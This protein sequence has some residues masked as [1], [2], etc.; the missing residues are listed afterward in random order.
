MS[1]QPTE[2]TDVFN[3]ARFLELGP[4]FYS[5]VSPSPLRNPAMLLWNSELAAELSLP[6]A[7]AHSE[8]NARLFSG[9]QPEGSENQQAD[10]FASVYSG[11]QFGV[12]AGQLGDGRAITL[13]ELSDRQ[14]TSQ[15]IQLKGAG[16]TPYSR[17]GDGR[18]VLRSSIREYLC[19]EAMHALG[20]PTTRALSLCGATDFVFREQPEN[21][22]V[23]CRVA[24]S[25][26]RFG[27]FE[28][29]YYQRRHDQLKQLADFVLSHYYPALLAEANPYQALLRE[30]AQRTARLIAAWQ[31]V[32]F[33][34]GVLNTDNMSMLGLT[35]DYG[36]FGFME[37]F[38]EQHICNHSDHQGRYAY[39]MQP[40]IGLWNLRALGQA[41]LPLIGSVEATEAALEHYKPSF[42][43]AW[44][45]QL[46][47]KFGLPAELA[48]PATLSSLADSWFTMLQNNHADFSLSFRRLSQIGNQPC[49]EDAAFTDLFIDRDS[50]SQWLQSYRAVLQADR[51]PEQQRRQAMLSHNPKY[52]LRNYLAQQAIAQAQTG[53]LSELHRLQQVLSRPFDEQAEHEEYAALPP[54]WAAELEVSCSS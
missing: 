3:P 51:R 32:G 14:Q 42:V 35:L 33:M 16:M 28:H 17:S 25:F 6:E 40:S 8:A 29:W 23:V 15:E 13:G 26:I 43:Q 30:V 24:P 22:A 34:H 31:A 37:A 36:P 27:H 54:D 5:R 19:S 2:F 47:N 49:K 45:Q 48:D 46:R 52:V 4:A 1:S 39:H 7:D 10:S 44:Q 53:D 38:N 21:A 9:S 50:A 41:L 11:H 12:W 18:A 20:I